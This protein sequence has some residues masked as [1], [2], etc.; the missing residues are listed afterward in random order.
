M[1]NIDQTNLIIQGIKSII[2]HKKY[3]AISLHEPN[4]KGTKAWAYTKDCIDS[5]W[6]SSAGKWVNCFEEEIS[7]YTNAKYTIAVTNGTVALRLALYLVG[8]RAGDEVLLPPMSFVASANAISHLG[9]N[10]HF[11]DIEPSSLGLCPNAL[12]DRL[13]E[14]C[15]MKN[16]NA[17][18]KET[19]RRIAALLP[20]HVFGNAAN[21][22]ELKK[23]ADSWS[24]PVVEDAAEALGS[25]LR[26]DS[27]FVHCG[28][29]GEIGI[30]SFNGNK[31]ITTGGGGVL[32][33][34]NKKFA[35]AAKHLSNTAK[36]AHPWEFNHDQI[37]WNDR[38]PNINAALGVSQIECLEKLL[39][40]KKILFDKYES[41]FSVLDN[42]ELIK[43][44]KNSLSN[45]W[46][47][48]LR[49]KS[50]EI[51]EVKILSQ[52]LI[53]KSHESNIFLRPVWKLLHRLPMYRKS[54]CGL[55]KNAENEE[56]RLVNLPSSPHLIE[57]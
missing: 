5:G 37:G 35:D 34:N 15:I 27:K 9:A 6:V 8:V 57:E 4:F 16:G 20:V 1:S 7:K 47:I 21:I 40:N 45:N 52:K 50:Q 46:L 49:F 41:F 44:S 38:M 30:I 11:I 39:K 10:P 22:F 29:I 19:G 25:W 32:I 31:L 13:N 51:K 53:S 48:T 36:L 17:F 2:N 54:P 14:I 55:L 42:I 18:N 33:T 28:L 23:I 3:D 24:I 43:S 56:N 12:K 26:K